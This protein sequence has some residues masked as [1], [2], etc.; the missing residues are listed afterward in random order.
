MQL[1]LLVKSCLLLFVILV[2][3]FKASEVT[4][5]FNGR[6]GHGSEIVFYALLTLGLLVIGLLGEVYLEHHHPRRPLLLAVYYVCVMSVA[7]YVAMLH[8]WAPI[9]ERY[10]QSLAVPFFDRVH[11]WANTRAEDIHEAALRERDVV[12]AE[13][14][15]GLG[16]LHGIRAE[17]REAQQADDEVPTKIKALKNAISRFN[18]QVSVLRKKRDGLN[19]IITTAG[20]I[21][22]RFIQHPRSASEM[23]ERGEATLSEIARLEKALGWKIGPPE[24]GS[25]V[26]ASLIQL[27][28]WSFKHPADSAV[29]PLWGSLLL[30][31]C[32]IVFTYAI[33][34]VYH[35]LKASSNVVSIDE[36]RK[37]AKHKAA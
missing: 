31:L 7:A 22:K 18:A 35:D 9:E 2:L 8:E 33:C 4:A 37:L 11:K 27:Y 36:A 17:L 15:A 26:K 6:L 34:G 28:A 13:I 1:G 23:T 20:N 19:K 3:G 30:S 10:L 32:L 24:F 14:I 25:N 5:L 21:P 12:A 16:K 29:G